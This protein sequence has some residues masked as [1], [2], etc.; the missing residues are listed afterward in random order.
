MEVAISNQ[1][2]TS[3]LRATWDSAASGWAKWE[4]ELSRN[5]VDATET[6]LDMADISSRMRIL[7][8]ACGAGS[9]SLQVAA[10]VGDGGLV[11]A[12]DISEEMLKHV[13]ENAEKA[14]FKNVETLCSAAEELAETELPFDG[15]ISRLGLMLFASPQ[16]ALL[17]IQRVLRPGARF[18]ALVFT[19]PANNPF[20]AHPM[21][22]ML[23]HA[24]KQPPSA[25]Q[26]G[27]FALGGEGVLESILS[28]SGF[29][30]IKTETV[31]A[32]L[33]LSS[34]DDA[35][36]MM[37]QAFGA[38]RAVIEDL[39]DAAKADAWADVRDYLGQFERE[40]GF[41]TEFEFI[42]GSGATPV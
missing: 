26:P 28:D 33:R 35:S 21:G 41:E 39:S 4:G 8:L 12:C 13:R 11:V 40:S 42:I 31:R 5:L 20:M 19:T 14:G 3:E 29:V 23:N 32:P 1:V 30:N 17:S 36:T 25:G 7:D 9:Q 18:A 24:A 6:L 2:S 37:Q 27:I 34:A 10:R 16:S 22:I 15:S 38:Y